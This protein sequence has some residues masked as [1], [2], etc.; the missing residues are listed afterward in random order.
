MT[1]PV[2]VQITWSSGSLCR[3]AGSLRRKGFKKKGRKGSERR[4]NLQKLG[5]KKP[6]QKIMTDSAQANNILITLRFN[7]APHPLR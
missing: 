6:R 5:T 2:Q 4:S 1:S 3:L 7:K